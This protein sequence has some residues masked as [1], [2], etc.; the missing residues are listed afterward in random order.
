[1][2]GWSFEAHKKVSHPFT[3]PAGDKPLESVTEP[4]RI[5]INSNIRLTVVC[6]PYLASSTRYG[7]FYGCLT[8]F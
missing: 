6:N 8:S 3:H 2:P 7:F 1:M 5:F 4:R